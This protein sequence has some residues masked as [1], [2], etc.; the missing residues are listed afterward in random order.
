MNPE[1]PSG[2]KTPRGTAGSR[3]DSP[4][5]GPSWKLLGDVTSPRGCSAKPIAGP[6]ISVPSSGP[7]HPRVL[8]IL[9]M[10]RARGKK[11]KEKHVGHAEA[12]G[13]RQGHGKPIEMP[14]VMR[15]TA[16][17]C[18]GQQRGPREPLSQGRRGRQPREGPQPGKRL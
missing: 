9:P 16:Q 18:P 5:S 14:H 3:E 1:S 10:R 17:G 15:T 7:A 4:P 2:R 13:L 6:N 8:Q 12:P 11:G